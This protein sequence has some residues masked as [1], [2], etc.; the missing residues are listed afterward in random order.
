M[1]RAR[2]IASTSDE[3]TVGAIVEL[4]ACPRAGEQIMLPDGTR[5]IDSVM[6]NPRVNGS[7]FDVYLVLRP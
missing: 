2:Y 5:L 7:E 3:G 6:H 1:I 4:A